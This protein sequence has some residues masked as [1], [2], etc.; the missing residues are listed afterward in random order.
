M[1]IWIVM[2]LFAF[3]TIGILIAEI[4]DSQRIRY[5]AK[6]LLMPLLAVFYYMNAY[7]V[8]PLLI[9]A[10]VFSFV[11]DVCLLWNQKKLL[12]AAGLISFFITQ[13]MYTIFMSSNIEWML[14]QP[15]VVYGGIA[16]YI[17]LGGVVYGFLFR[18]LNEMKIPVLVY[19]LGLISMSFLC[20]LYMTQNEGVASWMPFIGSLFFILSD[21]MLAFHSFKAKISKGGVYIM[22][23]Y[24]FAQILI[25]CGFILS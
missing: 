10:L 18:H 16:A 2:V 21:S 24:L 15:S 23:T 17:G 4:N 19:I 1:F 12:F 14:L 6:P 25:I 20:L 7:Q 11:G 22:A 5:F 8:S 13:L 3:S 9:T